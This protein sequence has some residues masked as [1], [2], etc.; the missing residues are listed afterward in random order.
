MGRLIKAEYRKI[1]TTKMWWALLVPSVLLA[2]GWAWLG[3]DFFSDVGDAADTLSGVDVDIDEM[4]WASLSLTRAMNF[5]TLF[6]MVFGALAVSSEINR[7]TITT[8]FLTAPTRGAVLT[9]KA[10]VYVVW[11]LVYGIVVALGATIG[12]A[13]GADSEKLPDTGEWILILLSGVLAC[14]LWTVLGMGVGA[15]LGSPVAALLVLLLYAGLVGPVMELIITPATDFSNVA[16]L[17]PNG[18]ANG[19]TGSTAAELLFQEVKDA[20]GGGPIPEDV[21][22]EFQQA[23]RLL[24]GAPGAF[25]MWLSGLIFAAWT[26]LFFITGMLRNN[27]RDIT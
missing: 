1:I 25:A 23:T 3:S 19:L 5:A 20:T 10:I 13:I 15:L 9:A 7:R 17:M 27:R 22:E 8:S 18:S 4:S 6:P 2:V 21:V 24:A 11:G 14:V 16:G 26:A 12:T